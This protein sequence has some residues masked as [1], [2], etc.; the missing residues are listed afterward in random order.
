MNL[1][2]KKII[3]SLII[4]MLTFTY[5][6]I[7]QE[8]IATS[9]PTIVSNS[10][11]DFE[12]YFMEG[13][14]KKS[15]ATQIIGEENYLYIN[16]TAKNGGYLKTGTI[17]LT[18][19]NFE[20]D[21]EI[22]SDAVS[23]FENN[24]IYLNQ[25]NSGDRVELAI[26]IKAK[27][28]EKIAVEDFNKQVPVVFEGKYVLPN[29]TEKNISSQITVGLIWD[30]SK[31][32]NLDH[33]I[34]RVVT[35][36]GADSHKYVAI[37]FLINS[38]LVGNKLPITEEKIEISLPKINL[39]KP[40]QVTV[41]ANS[42]K[43]IN[44]EEVPQTFGESNYTYNVDDNSLTILVANQADANGKISWKK[45]ANDEY[46]VTAVYLADAVNI[47]TS[48]VKI[49]YVIS[50]RV[51][52]ANNGHISKSLTEE[53]FISEQNSVSL[54]EFETKSNT[55]KI[56]KGQI[57]ANFDS[58]NKEESVY[59]ETVIAN[60]TY[61]D[62]INKV[63]I[64]QSA[65]DFV[66]ESGATKT[67]TTVGNVKNAYF[68]NIIVSKN[69]LEKILG[70]N[71]AVYVYKDSTLLATINKTTEANTDGN[72]VV[73]L[74]DANI[75]DIRIETSKPQSEGKLQIKLQKAIKGDV[76]YSLNQMKGFK[77]LEENITATSENSV[78][79][80]N[81]VSELK[82][83]ITLTEPQTKAELSIDNNNLSTVIL[84]ENVKLTTVLRTDS[85][86]YKLFKD[87]TLKITLPSYIEQIN[88]KNV[89]VLFGTEGSTL[90]VTGNQVI[91][92]PDGTKTIEVTLSGTQTEYT[93]G[94]V[95][96]GINVV[97][98]ADMLLNK[99]TPTRTDN[100]VLTYTNNNVEAEEL[101]TTATIRAVAPAGI[102]TISQVSGYAEGANTVT[103]ISEESKVANIT[104][105]A[106]ARTA[107]LNM[108]VVN[109]YQ[110]TIDSMTILGRTFTKDNKAPE[111]LTALGSNVDMPLASGVTVNLV[112]PSRVTVYYSENDSATK[113]LS[114]TANGW[115]T[116]PSDL[117]RV[118]SYLIVVSGSFNTGEGINFSYNTSIPASL[119]YNKA[120]YE[121]FAVYFN[122]NLASGT[123][124]DKAVATKL[125]LS[126]GK[127]PI[128]E[129]T[130][131]SNIS[132]DQEVQINEEIVYT[133]TVRNTGTEPAVNTV[134][135]F[136]LPDMLTSEE[137]ISG[138]ALGTVNVGSQVTK[139][140]TVKAGSAMNDTDRVEVKA[141]VTS[142]TASDVTTNSVY[143]TIAKTYYITGAAL[144]NDSGSALVKGNE[145]NYKIEVA[146]SG[147]SDSE[148]RR[149][150]VLE[151]LIPEELT[152]KN[153]VVNI[154]STTGETDITNSTT[155]NYNNN[156]RKLT[157]NLGDVKGSE[158]K[159]IFVN[160][161]INELADGV[162]SK[163]ITIP[164]TISG[165]GT[166]VQRIQGQPIEIGKI[167][168]KLTQSSTITEGTKIN[169]YEDFTYVFEVENLSNIM[170]YDVEL[171]DL[172]PKEVHYIKSEIEYE[173]GLT[174]NSFEADDSSNPVIKL[175]LN[176]K[177][178]ATVRLKVYANE[179]SSDTRI[180]NKAT[181]TYKGE[182]LA[183]SN[184]IRHTIAK[185]DEESYYEEIT[186]RTKR[187][188][189]QVWKD[190]SKDAIKDDNEEKLSNVDVILFNNNTGDL[191]REPNGD[192]LR[193]KTDAD[194]V[195]SF[196]NI[197]PGKY[198]VIFL[199]DTA[200][201]SATIYHMEGVDATKNSDAIDTTITIDGKSFVAAITE[202]ITVSDN[203]IYNI[204]LGLLED[205]KFDLS[206]NKTVSKITVT[207]S[208]GTKVTE[209]KD[210]KLA[211]Q[212]LVGKRVN[213]TTIAVEYKITVKNEGAV[214]GYVKK[215]VDYIPKD[216]K[217]S[218]E[219][220]RDWYTSSNGDIYNSS[221]ANTLINPGETKEVTLVLTKKMSD[222]NLGLINNN[223]EIFESYNDLGLPDMDSNVGNKASSEDDFSSADVL[224]T[225]KTGEAVLYIGIAVGIVTIITTA[226]I[227]I[228][229]KVIR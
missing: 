136:I 42:T 95:S 48:S 114:N 67:S 200:N 194:G 106:D 126:T 167:G 4:F 198:T 130:L 34:K 30:A 102:V 103:A 132:E 66:D 24:V 19:P 171:K 121:N 92:N 43:Q 78:G 157:V 208:T 174:K 186:N 72:Y 159:R 107:N 113:D 197:N 120:A 98:T 45:D 147:I 148:I 6:S 77:S 210:S 60:V 137:E 169:A 40:V 8:A 178:K 5:V 133:L 81:Q 206:L 93:L 61:A 139:Q 119:D 195:Y 76:S 228:K 138:I 99:L 156:T 23:K 209:F 135:N 91:S 20:I 39:E 172:L 141:N 153:I 88:V 86:D 101:T 134:A 166:R 207:D 199:Y 21:G 154:K 140:I 226:A 55:E 160:S 87:P 57:Y 97:V 47:T 33:E 122:N 32:L 201:Y 41:T 190:S 112:D 29:G 218:S 2:A 70:E 170:M 125:G 179:V 164:A 35:Y 131:S 49:G 79:L 94:A 71:G 143:N 184:E 28:G 105:M 15:G 142:D 123:V 150:T 12:V 127:G 219:V 215:I 10:N 68:K 193:V 44:G 17:T 64:E 165:T 182:L 221:L 75:N 38:E 108:Y 63:V 211:K 52:L 229:K 53:E 16:V 203:N 181:V 217:F 74:S 158:I 216:M 152:F 51:T 187:I 100:A 144:T 205:A 65:D 224:V 212:D 13:Q 213:E 115:T 69:N 22:E 25:I 151:A 168:V 214:P 118:K 162:Y 180:T 54:V 85:L 129:A 56:N 110:N 14:E 202:E 62:I 89:E 3:A 90:N 189:G 73:N 161:T 222:S 185:Y 18:E 191:V 183:T 173:S 128:L 227:I 36:T 59:E 145:L 50:D 146:S 83:T 9:N 82:N 225:V 177:A 96:K 84:N 149:N 37:Q 11:I 80:T 58:Q 220:N 176:G 188:T 104:P 26:P 192:I 109:N 196:G 155:Y 1:K 7:M 163:E 111:T 204:D 175:D 223:A 27:E 46:L 117:S 116:T 31:V 124:A